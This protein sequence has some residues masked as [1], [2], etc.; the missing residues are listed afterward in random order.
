MTCKIASCTPTQLAGSQ[1]TP[2]AIAVDA[3][4]IYWSNFDLGN[5][6]GGIMK[7]AKP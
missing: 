6:Q 1:R 7:L 5:S 4:A 3:T 2:V